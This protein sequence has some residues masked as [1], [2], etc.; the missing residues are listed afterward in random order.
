MSRYPTEAVPKRA[1]GVGVTRWTP[2]PQMV[3]EAQY[4]K[5]SF[6]KQTGSM[7]ACCVAGKT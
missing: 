6:R 4:I 1:G 2:L 3:V 5:K 7:R